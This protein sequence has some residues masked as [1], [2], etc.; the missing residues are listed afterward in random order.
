MYCEN[1]RG[2]IVGGRELTI[3]MLLELSKKLTN[4][5]DILSLAIRGLG[6]EQ[7]IVQIANSLDFSLAS[8][9]ILWRWMESQ[10]NERIAYSNLCLALKSANMYLVRQGD[11]E[12]GRCLANINASL[13]P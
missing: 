7:N 1:V 4:P 6:I 8:Y 2:F 13:L 5:H 12:E 9:R 10:V 11:F 3:S